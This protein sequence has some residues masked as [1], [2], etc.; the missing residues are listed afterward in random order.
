MDAR[1]GDNVLPGVI[2]PAEQGEQHVT[3]SRSALAQH[4]GENRGGLSD[5]PGL[6]R[7]HAPHHRSSGRGVD[8]VIHRAGP[9]D[10]GAA[11][12]RIWCRL[13]AVD[14]LRGESAVGFDTRYLGHLRI[15]PSLNP[16]EVQWLRGFAA[17]GALLDGDPFRLPRNPR[18][19][20]VKAFADAG[21]AM[22]QPASVPSGVQDW[23]VCE[24][25]DRI[26]WVRS[27][28]SNEA[29]RALTFLVEH[30][31]GPDALAKGCENPDFAAFTFDHRLDGV[32]VGERDDTDELFLL[33]VEGSTFTH[34]TLV[35]GVAWWDG[36]AALEDW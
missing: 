14:G 30:Y 27:A 9:V 12:S 26:T 16:A 28:R 36:P 34:E 17:W 31:L 15:T 24:H 10:D 8:V 23:R 4:I 18:A 6:V 20:L 1:D 2:A 11:S 33:R 22:S 13:D 3:R 5:V 7:G 35:A 32:I 19:A 29:E 21:G 25:G